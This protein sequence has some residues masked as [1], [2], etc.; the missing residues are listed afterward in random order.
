MVTTMTTAA[1]GPT[2]EDDGGPRRQ[3]DFDDVTSPCLRDVVD[4]ADDD[5]TS[6]TWSSRVTSRQHE[7][8]NAGK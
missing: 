8:D 6:T 2:R 7:H 5:V 4:S 1:H 3:R